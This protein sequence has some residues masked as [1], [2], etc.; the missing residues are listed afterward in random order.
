MNSLIIL[1]TI[2]EIQKD[3]STCVLKITAANFWLEA[4]NKEQI[5][6]SLMSSQITARLET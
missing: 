1:I 6:V 4:L 5:R 3:A 2:Y